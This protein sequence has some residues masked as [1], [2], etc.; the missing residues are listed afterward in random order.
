LPGRQSAADRNVYRAQFDPDEESEAGWCSWC[1]SI[2]CK[3]FMIGGLGVVV[4]GI[5]IAFFYFPG[6]ALL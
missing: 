1:A 5:T 4:I 2:L 6:D 3:C